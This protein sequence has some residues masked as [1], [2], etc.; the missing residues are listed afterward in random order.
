[1]NEKGSVIAIVILSFALCAS[2]AVGW[3]AVRHYKSQL[4]Q[5]RARLADAQN[6]ERDIADIVESYTRRT[7]RIFDQSFDTIGTIRESVAAL[8][9]EFDNLVAQLG[10]ITG[11]EHYIDCEH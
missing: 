6:R 4:G 1:M 5:L 2:C 10:G 11:S 8:E 3:T 9:E 7:E